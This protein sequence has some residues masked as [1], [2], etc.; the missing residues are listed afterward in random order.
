VAAVV[1]PEV[2][3]PSLGIVEVARKFI[4]VRAK[5]YGPALSIGVEDERTE[6]EMIMVVGVFAGLGALPGPRRF[7]VFRNSREYRMNT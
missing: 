2:G 7:F 5:V 6:V 3:P 1:D 4:G